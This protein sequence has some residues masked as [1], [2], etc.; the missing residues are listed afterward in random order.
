MG[1]PDPDLVLDSLALLPHLPAAGALIDIGSGGGL[2]GLALKIVRPSLRLVLLESNR[3]KAAFLQHAAAELGLAGVEV[4]ARRAE[5]AGREPALRDTFDVA[6][7]R[8]LA[9]MPV[10]VELCLPFV[11]PGGRLLA[12]KTAGAADVGEA[13][14]AIKLL[15]GELEQLAPAPS[16]AR[17]QGEVVIVRKVSSTPS[18]YP[19]RVGVPARRPLGK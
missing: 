3:R 14:V 15:G 2:P 13:E 18:E 4:V 11:R 16:S 7:A 8:A 10:L 19:R 9:P 6:T 17:S 12:M 5:E 1:N